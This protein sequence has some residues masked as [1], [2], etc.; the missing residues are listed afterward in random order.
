MRKRKGVIQLSS[1]DCPLT[2]RSVKTDQPSETNDLR[3]REN[4][5]GLAGV[6]NSELCLSV[7]SC[8][9]TDSARQV[10]TV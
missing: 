5:T 10:V 4:D 3:V 6:L 7:L 1:K 9:T 8:N 2:T